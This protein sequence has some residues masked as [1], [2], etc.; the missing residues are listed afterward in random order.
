[1]QSD[2]DEEDPTEGGPSKEVA[3]V[4]HHALLEIAKRRDI[5]ERAKDVSDRISKLTPPPEPPVSP[6]ES[7]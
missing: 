3:D 6:P 1:M 7:N 4:V 5:S 2:P